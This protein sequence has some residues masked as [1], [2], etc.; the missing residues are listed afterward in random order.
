LELGNDESLK[1][2]DKSE[3]MPPGNSYNQLLKEFASETSFGG[4]SKATLSHGNIRRFVWLL[5]SVICYCFAIMYCFLMVK[6]FFEKPTK[7]TVD[8]THTQVNLYKGIP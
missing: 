3:T 8:I 2:D 4:I 5:I 1:K 6:T 7:T